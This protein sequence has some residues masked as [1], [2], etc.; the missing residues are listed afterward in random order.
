[1]TYCHISAQCDAHARSLDDDSR[2]E[3]GEKVIDDYGWPRLEELARALRLSEDDITDALIGHRAGSPHPVLTNTFAQWAAD[4]AALKEP[5]HVTKLN[6][7][8]DA[9]I[10]G[11]QL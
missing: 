7:Q 8:I 11:E 4:A 6:A 2:D 5:A 9:Q 3:I 10:R 1:M